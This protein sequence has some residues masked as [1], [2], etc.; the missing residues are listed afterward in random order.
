M[1][2]DLIGPEVNF[3]DIVVRLKEGRAEIRGTGRK[4]RGANAC[5]FLCNSVRAALVPSGL[6][7]AGK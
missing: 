2:T 6:H 5:L 3:R 4:G 1:T 7:L